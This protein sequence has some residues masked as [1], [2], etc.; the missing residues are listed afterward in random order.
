MCQSKYTD[1][2]YTYLFGDKFKLIAAYTNKLQ[3][4]NEVQG[5]EVGLVGFKKSQFTQAFVH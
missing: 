2:Q 4:G 5:H 1:E 3:N